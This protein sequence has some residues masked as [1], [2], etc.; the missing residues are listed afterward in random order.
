MDRG[1][2][3]SMAAM[4]S[5][6]LA[7]AASA[8]IKA[9]SA[10]TEARPAPAQELHDYAALRTFTG[11]GS[12]VLLLRRG[13]SGYFIYDQTA[14]TA[15]DNGGTVIVS[16]NGRRWRRTYSG[17]LDVAWFGATGDFS[18][19]DS[20]SIQAAI[21]AAFAA[22]EGQVLL[23]ARHTLSR[24]ITV[25]PGVSILGRGP[26][27]AGG[28]EFTRIPGTYIRAAPDFEGEAL[29]LGA[30]ARP[31]NVLTAVQF[32]Q[33]RVDLSQCTA[34]GFL[35]RD[36]YDGVIF[37]NIHV[38]GTHE[39]RRACWL[40]SGQYGLGQTALFENCQ[41]LGKKGGKG[42]L[43]PFR[44]DAL[45]E[46]TFVNCKFFGAAGGA[47]ASS[48]AAAELSGCSG[49]TMLNCSFAF[50]AMGISIEEHPR[51]KSFG[52]N[53]DGGTFESL[54]QCALRIRS[55]GRRADSV[56]LRN[57]RYYDSVFSFPLAVDVDGV[58]NCHFDGLFKKV[59]VGPNCDQ[60]T[61]T[62]QRL[63]LVSSKGS[64]TLV[65]SRPNRIDGYL[66]VDGDI[67][68]TGNVRIEGN[69]VLNG[70]LNLRSRL[71]TTNRQRLEPSDT[72][73]LLK[74][75]DTAEYEMPAARSPS[76]GNGQVLI[77]R[78]VGHSRATL[79]ASGTD[80]IDGQRS[81][82]LPPGASLLMASDGA[83]GW[84]SVGS[85]ALTS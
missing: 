2:R 41:F 31:D 33:F 29:F 48:G 58:E 82:Q 64:N 24:P 18:N 70:S 71:V 27:Y 72:V 14:D 3:G 44:A 76:P 15:A 79:M 75:D 47:T 22:S 1:R 50:A 5:A 36:I 25:R 30:V 35:L 6:G 84:W 68:V 19:D 8:A 62:T 32:E 38:V 57:P 80:L 49:I 85:Q 4:V 54:T 60:T 45:N 66:G 46:S 52:I 26:A 37:R 83:S 39:L 55:A 51:R 21:D 7:L 69:A 40:T 78:N 73:V 67:R 74:C 13:I 20:H 59:L 61:I 10:Q 23:G 9:E 65:I 16:A 28:Q 34:H 56:S 77:V 81:L 42:S 11:D 43:A 63:Q 17:P 53:I 12:S